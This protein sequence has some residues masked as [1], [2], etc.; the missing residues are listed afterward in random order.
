MKKYSLILILIIIGSKLFSQQQSFNTKCEVIS[1]FIESSIKNKSFSKYNTNKDSV[2]TILDIDSIFQTCNIKTS[3]TFKIIN[4]GEKVEIVKKEGIFALQNFDR[5][6]YILISKKSKKIFISSIFCP[7][8]GEVIGIKY[9][10]KNKKYLV[11]KIR[12]GN[13]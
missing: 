12:S 2:I 1:Y 3:D 9:S 5:N 6:T 13:F 4:D 10:F 8:T 7:W 11:G